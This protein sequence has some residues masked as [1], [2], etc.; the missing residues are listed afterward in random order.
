MRGLTIAL[1]ICFFLLG[2]L[3]AVL[4]AGAAA[5]EYRVEGEL[6]PAAT[7]EPAAA[8]ALDEPPRDD[9]GGAGRTVEES[10]GE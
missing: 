8:R 5:A 3:W 10:Q 9:E 2:S 4:D 7:A 1:V 6:M